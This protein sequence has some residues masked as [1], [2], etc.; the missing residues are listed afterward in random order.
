MTAKNCC[1]VERDRS[2][3]TCRRSNDS[4]SPKS[5]LR[6]RQQSSC[7]RCFLRNT[8][9]KKDTRRDRRRLLNVFGV[10]APMTCRTS[11]PI[12]GQSTLPSA[13]DF[14]TYYRILPTARKD[15]LTEGLHPQECGVPANH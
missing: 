5:L 6:R 3:G 11:S 8:A 10:N 4:V 1:N 12:T 7:K 13:D 9:T 2:G 15:G 14:S